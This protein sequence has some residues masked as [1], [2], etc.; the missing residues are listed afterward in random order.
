MSTPEQPRQPSNFKVRLLIKQSNVQRRRLLLI[1][2]RPSRS[3]GLI[4]SKLARPSIPDKSH[5][6][7]IY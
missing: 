1:K 3:S 2:D 7:Y 4:Q 6:V 5:M